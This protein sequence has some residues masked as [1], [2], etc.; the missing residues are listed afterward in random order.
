MK[1]NIQHSTFN[2]QR[3]LDVRETALDVGSFISRVTA[4][5]LIVFV[6]LYRWTLSP[7]KTFL[8]GPL[9]QCRFTP[10]CSAYALEALKAHGALNGS[11]LAVKRICRCHPWGDCGH[12]PV[13]PAKFRL[14]SFGFRVPASRVTHHASRITHHELPVL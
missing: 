6:H 8:C 12:D 1:E 9:A 7:A 13:P 3:P 2:I 10:S 5:L 4:A 11:W 14:S